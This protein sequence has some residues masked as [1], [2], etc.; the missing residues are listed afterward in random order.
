MKTIKARN[1][2]I[3]ALIIIGAVIFLGINFYVM[4]TMD[5]NRKKYYKAQKQPETNDIENIKKYKNKYM[6]NASNDINLFRNLPLSDVPMTFNLYP[7]DFGIEVNYKKKVSDIGELRTMKSL[8]YN[9][10]AAF[11]LIDNLKKISYKFQ[12]RKYTITREEIESWY[13]VKLS[14]LLYKDKWETSVQ[15]KL[16]DA[17]YVEHFKTSILKE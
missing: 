12:D 1:E 10:T 4:P 9:S 5:S 15:S 2:V 17:T 14:S 13:G 8:A 3:I 16:K 11:A 6:G 7:Y